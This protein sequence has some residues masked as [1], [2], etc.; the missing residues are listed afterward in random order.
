MRRDWTEAREKCE[1]EGICRICG[2]ASPEPAHLWHRGRGGDMSSNNI[3]PL[4]RHHHTEFDSHRLDILA[5]LL[6][7]EQVEL[8]KQ[9]GSI[10]TARR[11][12][13]PSEY[14]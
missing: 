1:L 11:R 9:A 10:E 6:P 2:A 7:D 13:L 5:Y 3:V 8:V 12:V 14:R 4:C